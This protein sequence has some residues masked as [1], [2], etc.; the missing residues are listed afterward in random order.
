MPP[1][2]SGHLPWQDSWIYPSGCSGPTRPH[3]TY[4]TLY[5]YWVLHN[6]PYLS[7]YRANIMFLWQ[8]RKYKRETGNEREQNICVVVIYLTQRAQRTR[9]TSLSS[10][11]IFIILCALCALCVK[12]H[13]SA[14]TDGVILSHRLL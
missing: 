3:A 12:Y 10:N 13:S 7:F 1:P 2:W 6:L 4:Q 8:I 11:N 14:H 9:R 5:A